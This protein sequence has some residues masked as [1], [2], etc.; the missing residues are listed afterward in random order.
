MKQWT[1]IGRVA[2]LVLTTAFADS[3]VARPATSEIWERESRLRQNRSIDPRSNP[4]D[5][6]SSPRERNSIEDP[7]FED[8][9]NS[10]ESKNLNER[11]ME[12]RFGGQS[13]SSTDWFLLPKD[14]NRPRGIYLF[15]MLSFFVPGLD[16]WWESQFDAAV[17][18]SGAF[19]VSDTL[20]K[21]SEAQYLSGKTSAEVK[22]DLEEGLGTHKN[23]LR[24]VYLFSQTQAMAGGVS[25]YHSFRSAVRTRPEDF[26]FLGAEEKLSDLFAAPFKFEFI[27][28][29]TSW[30]PLGAFA[31]FNLAQI[32]LISRETIVEAGFRPVKVGGDDLAYG[33][34]FS[35]NAGTYEEMVFRG[36][37]LPAMRYQ[38]GSPLGANLI[39]TL[40]FAFAHRN[41]VEVPLIQGA[42]GYYFG[43]LTM[44]SQYSIQESIFIHTWWDVIA[45]AQSY[46]YQKIRGGPKAI[47]WLPGLNLAF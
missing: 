10:Q 21:H 31:L 11:R 23:S 28:K 44:N 27:T 3:L 5:R 38:T 12:E 16:Q 15:P 14:P 17:I 25:L 34:A 43:W 29:P 7:S 26:D 8:E 6:R 37:L 24:N 35:Y 9:E 46:H 36:W 42:L 40:A 39:S 22:L 1:Y 33:A 47:L 20:Q 32:R 41:T 18:Y 30:V 13:R 45:F 19:L 4:M 2:V